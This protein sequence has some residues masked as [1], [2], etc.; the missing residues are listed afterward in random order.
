MPKPRVCVVGSCN[1]DLTFRTAR[2]PKAGET[3]AGK[4]FQLAF[5]G[6]GANQAVM[7]ARLGAQVSLVSC[8]GTDLFGDH[9]LRNLLAEGIDVR[10]IRRDAGQPTGVA[11][12]VVDDAARN[13][14]LVV[15]GAN[16]ALTPDDAR[17]AAAVIQGADVLLCQLEV[18][19]ETVVEALRIAKAGGVRT[20]LN[21]AP[22][23]A[24]TDEVLSLA[25]YCVPNETEAE[26]LTGLGEPKK[27]ALALRKRGVR[28]VLLT[29]GE[30][31]V[32]VADDRGTKKIPS[33]GVDA[34]DPTGAGDAFIGAFA[35]F[36][37]EGVELQEAV[38]R[39]A[40][41]AALTVTKAG[42]QT[43]Y[44]RRSEA[45]EF[46]AKTGEAGASAIGGAA[47]SSR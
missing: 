14:I 13:S 12:I 17:G 36:L 3:L 16:G 47:N 33:V 10:H 7:A 30:S 22:A 20:V 38:R 9:V 11:A 18:P 43:S 2:L 46:L 42:A 19:V 15:A 21:P 23:A 27:A 31:G 24:L 37:V 26:T 29:C 34:V 28:N 32:L 45:E 6:K 1:L 41:V 44:P 4:S 5:G 40:A 25:D 8:V 39:A 35:V